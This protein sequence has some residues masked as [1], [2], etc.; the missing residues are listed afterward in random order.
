MKATNPSAKK[1]ARQLLEYGENRKGFIGP[2]ISLW[3][4]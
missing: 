2:E 4:K 1:F 3:S